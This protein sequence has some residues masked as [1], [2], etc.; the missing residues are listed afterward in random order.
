MR[1]C[2]KHCHQSEGK[3]LAQLR[4]L[5]KRG[6]CEEDEMRAYRCHICNA[7]HVGHR[8]QQDIEKRRK[9]FERRKKR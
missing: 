8:T 2:G 3:A 5:V 7:W 9:Y 1:R 4:S 6:M